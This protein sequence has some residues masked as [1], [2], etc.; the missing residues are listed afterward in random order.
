M[1]PGTELDWGGRNTTDGG[2]RE[3][4]RQGMA[5]TVEWRED[6]DRGG[7]MTVGTKLN[8]GRS[9]VSVAWA[10]RGSSRILER[11]DDRQ[12]ERARSKREDAGRGGIEKGGR[13]PTSS[14][15]EEGAGCRR[16]GQVEGVLAFWAKILS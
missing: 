14:S 13:P 15:I 10:R 11:E 8:R 5:G 7:R 2:V 16:H 9:K 6:G 12:C 1:T 3:R 4:E